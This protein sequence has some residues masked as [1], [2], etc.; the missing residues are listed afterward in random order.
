[1]KYSI[2][3]VA[4]ALPLLAH[5]FSL[6]SIAE[7]PSSVDVGGGCKHAYEKD[8]KQCTSLDLKSECSEGCLK[9]LNDASS[10]IILACRMD[11]I[12][13]NGG[14]LP[15]AMKGGDSLAGAVCGS[16]GGSDDDEE[17]DKPAT[18]VSGTT[19][20]AST[21]TALPTTLVVATTATASPSDGILKD[22]NAELP[23]ETSNPS[24]GS[25][26]DETNSSGGGGDPFSISSDNDDTSAAG[27]VGA[28]SMALVVVI[29]VAAAFGSNL[30]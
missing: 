23:K 15:A 2:A 18:K 1:M 30:W 17:E 19:K 14:L 11:T 13:D 29:G 4:A 25:E 8:I 9:A 12:P 6:S 3:F 26:D 20:A 5:T 22:D 24:S 27:K 16:Q 28:S 7:L 10:N 21:A